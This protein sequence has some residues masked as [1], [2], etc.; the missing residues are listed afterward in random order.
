MDDNP[1]PGQVPSKDE[2]AA[3]GLEF[4]LALVR[5]D[6]RDNTNKAE[7]NAQNWAL[8]FMIR[9]LMLTYPEIDFLRAVR[10]EN[11]FN[12]PDRILDYRG[13]EIL[14]HCTPFE[15]LRGREP[16]P[17]L[18][19]GGIR[20]RHYY[21]VT[22]DYWSVTSGRRDSRT[23]LD[24]LEVLE[25]LQKRREKKSVKNRR[26]KAK[27]KAQGR[28]IRKRKAK[29]KTKQPNALQG[30]IDAVFTDLRDLWGDLK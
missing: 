5:R 30:V 8:Y 21:D 4:C 7:D 6:E 25:G 11:P 26:E 2:F 14:Y 17:P 15:P 29:S 23:L 12:L 18:P 10:T 28:L 22:K 1:T 16:L 13:G 3:Y 9:M 24:I 27:L 20:Y 19:N